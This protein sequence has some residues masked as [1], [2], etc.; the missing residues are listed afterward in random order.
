MNIDEILSLLDLSTIA[1]IHKGSHSQSFSGSVLVSG[2][3]T[4]DAHEQD[5]ICYIR[6]SRY[7][8]MHSSAP[9]QRAFFVLLDEPVETVDNSTCLVAFSDE[10][11]FYG[12]FMLVS[13]EFRT[14]ARRKAEL[15]DLTRKVNEGEGLRSIVNNLSSIFGIPCS[16][17]DTSLAY[18]ARS[19]NF[20]DYIIRPE[21]I[22]AGVLP[23]DAI[24]LMAHLQ[25]ITPRR[26]TEVSVFSY[27]D[28]EN[29]QNTV[30]NH[31][32]FIRSKNTLIGS[33]S[34]FTLNEPM[35]KSYVD[36]LP[37]AAQILGIA[38]QRTDV[39]I[40]SRSYLYSQIFDQMEYRSEKNNRAVFLQRMAAI[41]YE[42]KY[43]MNIVIVDF[44]Q[45]SLAPSQ[46]AWLASNL[47][48]FIP[49]SFY[50]VRNGE[51]LF[52]SSSEEQSSTANANLEAMDIALEGSQ[53]Q[54]GFSHVFID[55]TRTPG[56]ISQAR[57]AIKLG[58][59]IQASGRFHVFE[60]LCLMDLLS[61]VT[62][63]MLLYS[64]R[65]P[66]LLK[67]ID[68]DWRHNSKLTHTLYLY[69]QKPGKP[70]E[71]AEELFIHKNT[72][73]YR[74]DKIKQTMNVDISSADVIAKIHVSF[75]VLKLQ[76]R[77]D[78]MVTRTRTLETSNTDIPLTS[79]APIDSASPQD[80]NKGKA[81]NANRRVR[82]GQRC[83]TSQELKKSL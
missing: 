32:A 24:E 33:V 66:P 5:V 41:G 45:D 40:T 30:Y 13:R 15:L 47:Q 81:R 75:L 74:L 71:V 10:N 78:V 7:N 6:A 82:H 50:A 1:Y 14:L 60:D 54:V 2:P 8:E 39:D 67:L 46:A 56:A 51:I 3:V 79:V 17:L 12:A 52:F 11:A 55:S 49:N 9:T 43:Y 25:L 57:R 31:M 64:Y 44:T 16:V 80:E 35:R 22:S 28:H 34:F 73:Y 53:S 26:S 21:D 42:L 83:G 63:P 69:L 36:M 72:L 70:A 62:D 27:Q 38:M 65:Y 48:T 76:N 19:T 77:F 20:P 68:Y 18:L 59:V 4:S 29:P 61:N 58:R 37:A 23:E